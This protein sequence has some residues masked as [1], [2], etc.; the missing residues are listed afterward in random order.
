MYDKGG[1]TCQVDVAGSWMRSGLDY[2]K[3]LPLLSDGQ[4]SQLLPSSPS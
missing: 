4:Q 3:S 1:E 2:S